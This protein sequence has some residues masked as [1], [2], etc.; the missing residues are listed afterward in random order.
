LITKR[1]Q[2]LSL[3]FRRAFNSNGYAAGGI[4]NP[5]LLPVFLGKPDNKGT[6]SQALDETLD[7]DF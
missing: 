5:A 1:V 6:K 2:K 7:I 4:C 3:S